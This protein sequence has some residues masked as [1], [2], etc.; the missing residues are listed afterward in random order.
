A[1]VQAQ[2]DGGGGRVRAGMPAVREGDSVWIHE[3]AEVAG[4]ARIDG[5]A[6]ICAGA[7]VRSGAWVNGPCV[8]GGYTTIDSGAKIS[9]SIMW[10]HSYVGLNSRLRGAVVCRSV[11]IKNGCLLEEGSVI[12]GG[13][14]LGSGVA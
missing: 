9:N 2:C 5:P 3:E 6:L 12:G 8:I 4:G 7:Q 14:V 1:A 13:V 10:D 11:T